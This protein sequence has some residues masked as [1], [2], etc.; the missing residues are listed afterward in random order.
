MLFALSMDIACL[1]FGWLGF[2]LMALRKR[3]MDAAGFTA[4]LPEDHMIP[5]LRDEPIVT[6]QPMDAARA[7][8]RDAE[9]GEELVQVKPHW[10]KLKRGRKHEVTTTPETV[11]DEAGV[12]DPDR[13]GRLAEPELEPAVVESSP[14]EGSPALEMNDIS[15]A[16]LDALVAEELGTNPSGAVTALP[17]GEGVMVEASAP[18]H[19]AHVRARE[20]LEAA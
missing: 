5:D 2:E 1:V 13:T 8:V 10:R 9:T 12:F 19:D 4:D 14:P 16:E 18:E 20:K 7:V 3:Q 6:P 11:T 15:D 17:D